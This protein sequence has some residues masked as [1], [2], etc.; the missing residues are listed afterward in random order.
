MLVTPS[1]STICWT[2][3]LALVLQ[4]AMV[5]EE[6]ISGP[7]R[8]A[9]PAGFIIPPTPEEV[10]AQKT[11]DQLVAALKPDG[12]TMQQIM[13]NPALLSGF[14][15]PDVMRA[16]NQ[17]AAN[18]ANLQKYQSNKKVT[19]CLWHYLWTVWDYGRVACLL[20]AADL[21]QDAATPN[22]NALTNMKLQ[23]CC[24][25]DGFLPANE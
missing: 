23:C 10:A 18:P 7:G 2:V 15:D 3:L 13:G 17:I 14:D 1:S 21:C 19:P 8:P 24:T 12:N 22:Q 9:V 25:G 20:Q 4:Q 6:I 11:R 16:V 5:I